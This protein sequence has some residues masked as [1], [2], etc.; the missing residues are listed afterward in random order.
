MQASELVK[1]YNFYYDRALGV[2]LELPYKLDSIKIPINE[3]AYHGTINEVYEKL[4]TNLVY[5][6]SSTKLS[7]NNI[8]VNYAKIAGGA[9][10]PLYSL[11]GRFNWFSTSNNNVY[12]ANMKPLSAYGLKELDN[13]NSGAFYNKKTLDGKNLGFFVSNN[14]IY[15]LTGNYNNN[16]IGVYVSSNKVTES[17]QFNFI[18]LNSLAFDEN[19]NYLYVSDTGGNSIY[20]YDISNLINE[21]NL[22]GRKIL[23]VDSIGGTGT[24]QDTDKFDEPGLLN[25]YNN[26][27]Y[28]I[29]KKNSCMKVY[30]SNLNWKKTFRNRNIFKAYNVTAF[31]PNPNNDLFYMGFDTR[32]GI[33]NNNLETLSVISLSSNFTSVSAESIVDFSFSKA[34][35]NIF[36]IITNK[37]IYKRTLSRPDVHVGKFLLDRPDIN[38]NITNFKFSYLDAYDYNTDNFVVYGKYNNAGMF[39]SFLEDS[40]YQSILANNDLDFYT[41]DEIKI[42]P[43]EYIQDWVF[44]KANYK[45][46]LN[47]LSMRDRLVKRFAGKYDQYG[48]NLLFGS[49]YLLDNEIQKTQFDYSLNYFIGL[50]ENFSNTVFNRSIEKLY[51][52]QVQMLSVLR[53]TTINIWPP[54]SALKIV[55]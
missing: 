43:D 14:Y 48:N 17:S 41:I 10:T 34:D 8:P 22:I 3:I 54:V 1:D 51:N 29:D 20:Q 46:L 53:D 30:D 7:D 21:D 28:V 9:P 11:S 47:I 31:R 44:T 45:I 2:K 42:N 26:Y 40:N 33:F 23:Y 49:L 6:Y 36:Y 19:K 35:T 4:Q 37:N 32:M 13:L 38:I 50:N 25:I 15:A 12:T 18:K 55:S 24:Y 16:T 27:L 52:L 5:L 39:L